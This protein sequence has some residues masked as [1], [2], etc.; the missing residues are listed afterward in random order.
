MGRYEVTQGQWKKVMGAEWKKE[1]AYDPNPRQ[2]DRYPLDDVTWYDARDFVEK[3]GFRLPT[4]AE[5][6]YA[7]RAGTR[8]V[9]YGDID[10]IAWHGG[11]SGQHIHEGGGKLA[12]GFG[13]HDM[14][15][16]VSEWCSDWDC[17]APYD[18]RVDGVT[19]PQGPKFGEN[20]CS[21]GAGAWAAPD[22][23]RPSLRFSS[24]PDSDTGGSGFRICRNP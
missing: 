21:R 13:L 15:G 8:G 19:D 3:A 2:G 17:A 14:I 23:Q 18:D 6:E 1:K 4:E 11:N 7:C 20:R 10:A 9:F 5:W 16:N 24:Q 12:N 22:R